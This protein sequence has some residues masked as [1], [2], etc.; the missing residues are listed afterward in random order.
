LVRAD[1]GHY[2]LLGDKAFGFSQ[3]VFR[4]ALGI[5]ID[6]LDLCVV[7]VRNALLVGQRQLQVV[8]TVDNLHRQIDPAL[9]VHAGGSQIARQG[10][11]RADLNHLLLGQGGSGSDQEHGKNCKNRSWSHRHFLLLAFREREAAIRS[12]YGSRL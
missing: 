11:K 1:Q 9:A 6:D 7:K 5:G 12:P 4:V 2:F 10:I 3:S 8:P